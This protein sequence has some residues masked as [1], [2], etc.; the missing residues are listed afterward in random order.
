LLWIKSAVKRLK[1]KNAQILVKEILKT[2]SNDWW[3]DKKAQ[4][5]KWW[6]NRNKK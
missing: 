6:V 2:D 4:K 1:T 5:S 3:F